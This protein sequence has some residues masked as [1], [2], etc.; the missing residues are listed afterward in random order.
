MMSKGLTE[1][2]VAGLEGG[3]ERRAVLGVIVVVL[4]IFMVSTLALAEKGPPDLTP[5]EGADYRFLD[6][7]I[8]MKAPSISGEPGKSKPASSEPKQTWEPQDRG[9][10]SPAWFA[11][12]TEGFEGDW[13]NQ[14]QCYRAGGAADAYWGDEDDGHQY[15]G[16]W[17]G[18]CADDGTAGVEPP[19][20]YPANMDAWMVYG[21]FSL[22]DATDAELNFYHWTQTETDYDR[23]SVYASVD[24]TN[25]YG[26]YWTGDW[27][28]WNFYSF[29]LTNVYTLGNLCG[30]RQVWIAFHFD[31]DYSNQYEGTY[32]DDI[33]LQKKGKAWTIAVYLAADNSLGSQG[34]D[35]LDFDEMEKAL[36]TSAP[37]LNV[38]V[39]WDRPNTNDTVMYLVQPDD[40]EGSSATYTLDTNAWYIPPGWSFDYSSGYPVGA[41]SPSEENMGSQSTLTNF[42]NWVFYNFKSDYYGLILWNHGGGW[43]PKSKAQPK[44]LSLLLENG[45]TF[46]RTFFPPSEPVK[47]KD[48]K[49]V[50]SDNQDPLSRGI[51]WDDTDSGDYLTTKEVAYGIE[52]SSRGWVDNLGFDACLMQM[53]EVAYEMYSTPTV[54]CDYLTASEESEWGYGWAYHQILAGI[55]AATTPLQLALSW[56]STKTRFASGGLDTISSLDIWQVGALASD[57]AALA[58]RLSSLLATNGRYQEIMYAK[59]LSLCF[60][61]NEYLDLDDFCHLI[62]AF[63]GDTTAQN[64]AQAVRTQISSTVVAKANGLGYN[65]AGGISIYMPHWHDIPRYHSAGSVPHG[66]YNTTNFAFCND[67]TWDTFITNWLATDHADPYESNNTPSAAYNRGTF[68]PNVTY[69]CGETDFDDSTPDWYKFTIPFPCNITVWA[70]CTEYY[71]DSKIYLYDSLANANADNYFASDDDGLYYSLGRDQLGS[72]L[73]STILSAGTYYLKVVPYG[74]S[75]GADEDYEVWLS[76]SRAPTPAVFRVESTG[77]V[78]ADGPFYGTHFYSGSADVAEWVHVS[79]P[80]ESGDVLE[81]D[82][83]NPGQYRRSRGECSDLVAGVVSTDPGFGLGSFFSTGDSG[84]ATEDSALLALVGVVPVKITDEG[85][86]IHAGD[87][88]VTSSTLGYAMRWDPESGEHCNFVGKALEPLD[89]DTGV[90]QVLLMR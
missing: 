43:E 23:F 18:Y 63:I 70:W 42:M 30:E 66:N 77:D 74:G 35:Q 12:K 52:N 71:S 32:L 79:E 51:C 20:P 68:S 6:P 81:L 69:L 85:G 62:D 87:L 44:Q 8:Y 41:G 78:L 19:G 3:S 38:I 76:A 89:G 47:V 80:V 1:A 58:D 27:G 10:R 61:Y 21:P 82:P 14:W 17:S 83:E 29:D 59:L 67:H 28:G 25:F 39:L 5:Q 86:P 11:I 73:Y 24:G 26:R 31:S 88:L 54:A 13:P 16:G 53:L 50:Q 72:Y 75:Y 4:A 55:T 84:L 15:D 49:D 46:E 45:E 37:N 40:T 60:A 9:E 22:Q 57:V 36:M 48:P 64:L 34:S 90:I 2:K 65:S 56:G 7:A 33:V